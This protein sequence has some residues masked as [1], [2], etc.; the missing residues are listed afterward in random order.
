MIEPGG[1][2]DA[3]AAE[4]GTHLDQ[5]LRLS[6]VYPPQQELRRRHQLLG[7]AG[8][9]SLRYQP[10]FGV[11]P[12]FH[13]NSENRKQRKQG[14]TPF[15][16]TMVAV[17]C[18]F[19]DVVGRTLAQ[20][21]D[22]AVV[23][24]VGEAAGIA[25]EE[26]GGVRQPFLARTIVRGDAIA[27]DET[28]T[29]RVAGPVAGTAVLF[30]DPDGGF[31]G[32]AADETLLGYMAA[33]PATEA[34]A[35]GRLAWFAR[36]LE[37]PNRVIADDAFAEFGL[38]A[39][40]AVVAAAGSLDAEKLTAWVEEP[41]IDHRRRGFYGLALGILAR[42]AADAGDTERAGARIAALEQALL[43]EGSDLRAGYD[44]L[45]G[46]L[47]VAHGE[48][49]LDWLREHG[50]LAA[51]TRAGDAR[52]TLAALRF[53]WEYLAAD[54]PRDQV[55][56]AAAGLLANPAVAADTAVD[57]ARWQHWDRIEQVTALWDRLGRD[58]PLVR[59][60][61]AGYLLSCPLPA[62]KQ[63]AAAIAAA[64]PD[65]WAAAVAAASLPPRAAD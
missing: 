65:A 31:E 60:A 59:R 55:A 34:D 21:R 19:C 46:G 20:R 5:G 16:L 47:L 62:A 25:R 64:D 18:P 35:A 50:L 4:A 61:V 28:V 36:W 38:A 44:G 40:E 33:A 52:H 43:A 45:L 10:F 39:F 57:L 2:P 9:R 24:A 48:A 41:A 58:D 49:A 8:A 22:A 54:V 3:E 13:M 37:H 6:A 30:G 11:R 63:H 53:A 56:A 32:V 1:V 17:A 15:C 26:S 12:R 23:V 29:A 51:D 42:R 14:L 27:V 7:N